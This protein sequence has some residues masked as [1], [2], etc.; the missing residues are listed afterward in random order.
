MAPSNQTLQDVRESGESPAYLYIDS[1][2]A[3]IGRFWTIFGCLA[4]LVLFW[5]GF[6]LCGAL[7]GW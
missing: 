2:G 7:T 1:Q 3:I 5:L 4:P 6:V